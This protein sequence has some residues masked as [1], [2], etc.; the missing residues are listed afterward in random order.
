MDT[1]A[2]DWTGLL[3]QHRVIVIHTPI[4]EWAGDY[5]AAALFEE[6]VWRWGQAGRAETCEVAG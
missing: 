1:R 2:F 4:L 6:L 5:H 3:G